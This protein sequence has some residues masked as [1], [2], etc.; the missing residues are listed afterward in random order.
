MRVA[1]FSY[2]CTCWEV[3]PRAAPSFCWLIASILRRIRT[4]L[5]TCW[6]VR[7]FSRGNC[8]RPAM[9]DRSPKLRTK[10]RLDAGTFDTPIQQ[11][12]FGQKR[13]PAVLLLTRHHAQAPAVLDHSR[14]LPQ[15][16]GRA[17]PA[18][19]RRA[20][21]RVQPDSLQTRNASGPGASG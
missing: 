21:E 19:T 5:P 14:T 8:K 7:V 12:I 3:R 2:F 20:V 11:A 4:R 10:N 9:A 15:G 6:S 17:G 13:K 18:F 16:D 1:P